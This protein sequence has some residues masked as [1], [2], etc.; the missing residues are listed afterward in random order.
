MRRQSRDGSVAVVH[1]ECDVPQMDAAAVCKASSR[2]AGPV[3]FG[4]IK[5]GGRGESRKKKEGQLRARNP[6]SIVSHRIS[7]LPS[8]ASDGDALSP[9]QSSLGTSG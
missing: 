9:V 1:P 5:G 7:S 4:V 3:R 6:V 2:S 8:H